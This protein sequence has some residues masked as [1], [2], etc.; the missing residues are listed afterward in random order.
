MLHICGRG[1]S[2]VADLVTDRMQLNAR[3]HQ[4]LNAKIPKSPGDSSKL[5]SNWERPKLMRSRAS[6]NT[7]HKLAART[8]R[9]ERDYAKKGK[10]NQNT[11]ESMK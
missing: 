11:T 6:V 5:S 9:T 2:A 1:I 7:L 10:K 8:S 4:D 3:K